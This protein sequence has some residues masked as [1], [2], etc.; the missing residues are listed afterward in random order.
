MKIRLIVDENIGFLS[1]LLAG[2]AEVTAMPGRR[3]T[4]SHVNG[5]DAL[6]VRAVTPVNE[7]LLAGTPV[8]F[9]GTTTSGFDHVDVQWLNRAGI[10]FVY[11]PGSNANSV[12]EYVVA[13]LLALAERRLV[14][15]DGRVLGVIG[16]GRVGTLVAGKARAL[17]LGVRLN[18]PPLHDI[19]GDAA[20]RPLDEV[21]EQ[22]DI[23]S[24]HVPLTTSGPYPTLRMVNESFF[25]RMKP[26]TVFINT[27]RGAVVDEDA[28]KRAIRDGRIAAAVLDVWEG[29]PTPDQDLVNLA[30]LAT[31][32]IAGYSYNGKINAVRQVGGALAGFFNLA[33]NMGMLD[34]ALPRLTLAWPVDAT[35]HRQVLHLL[36]RQVYNIQA[37]DTVFRTA[38]AA[39]SSSARAEAFDALRKHY[40][41]RYEFH[42]FTI[43]PPRAPSTETACAMTVLRALGFQ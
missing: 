32:H 21:L 22:A 26:G 33:L 43:Q 42:T 6:I 2:A 12:A 15:L 40:P 18:D 34:E 27:S 8:R 24:L 20:Y 31:P 41:R 5:A 30:A 13:A 38:M 1:S 29:E 17:G 9:V 14:D 16:A 19:T 4:R 39:P 10:H 23:V 35:D 11:A 36:V 28:L 25:E 3:I 7:P 37:D